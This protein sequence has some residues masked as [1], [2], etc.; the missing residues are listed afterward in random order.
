MSNPSLTCPYCVLQTQY[1]DKPGV[2][3]EVAPNGIAHSYMELLHC[4]QLNFVRAFAGDVTEKAEMNGDSL[5]S[6]C[7]SHLRNRGWFVH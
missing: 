3:S 5:V 7:E 6:R 2:S 4:K 1:A